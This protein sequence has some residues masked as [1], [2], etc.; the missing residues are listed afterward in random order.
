MI[1]PYREIWTAQQLADLQ[2]QLAGSCTVEIAAFDEFAGLLAGDE[3]Q[4]FDH[5]LFDTAPT[6]HTLRLLSLPRAWTGFLASSTRGASCLGPH[7][8]LKMRQDR[9][10]AALAALADPARATVVMVT[11]PDHAA[12]READRTSGELEALGLGNQQLVVNAVFE[13]RDRSDPVAVALERRGREAL[14]DMPARLRRLPS[15]SVPLRGFN[16]VGLPALRALL[17]ATASRSPRPRARRPRRR[18]CRRWRRSSTSWPRRAT[19]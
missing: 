5:V 2:E 19:G 9:F 4:Q 11:R 7:S 13:A 16:M 17:S 3:G 6:G 1:A 12:L 18:S 10:A 15:L 14:A 8:G